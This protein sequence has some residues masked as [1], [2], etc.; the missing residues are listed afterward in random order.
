MRNLSEL[1][2]ER[3]GELIKLPASAN[4]FLYNMVRIMVGTLLR[5]GAGKMSS[6][7]IKRMLESGDRTLGGKTVPPKGLTLLSVEY[8]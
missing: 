1:Q 6:T 5:V 7:V 4:G 3:V 2:V 8:E